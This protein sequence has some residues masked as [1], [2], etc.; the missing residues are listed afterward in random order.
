MVF[1]NKGRDDLKILSPEEKW[2]IF[3]KYKQDKVMEPLIQELCREEE[4]IM[5]ANKRID[6][7]SR[8]SEDWARA[9]Y[10]DKVEMDY[11]SGLYASRMAGKAEGKVEGKAEGIV[12][13]TAKGK[14]EGIAEAKAEAA[15][16]MKAE[17]DSIEKISRITGLSPEQIE[18]L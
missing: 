6:R 13:G 12:E 18:K 11:S 8:R 14:V 3:F 16:N 2:C 10:R 1:Y 7:L 9:L 15:R 5:L 17:G 4:G